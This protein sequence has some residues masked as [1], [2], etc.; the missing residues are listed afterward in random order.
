MASKSQ[1]LVTPISMSDA[2]NDEER[3]GEGGEEEEE[4]EVE[5]ALD[6]KPELGKSRKRKGE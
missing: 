4:G 2:G 6:V 3:Q 5:R 1:G